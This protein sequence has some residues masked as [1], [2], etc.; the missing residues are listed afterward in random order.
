MTKVLIGELSF[1]ISAGY[2]SLL[3]SFTEI[4][5]VKLVVDSNELCSEIDDYKPDIVIVNTN[6]LNK[7]Q[8]KKMHE[9]KKAS[10][11]V[12]HTFNT[13]LPE[14]APMSQMSIYDSRSVLI[15]KIEAC[16][17]AIKKSKD[18]NDAEELSERERIILQYVALGHTNKE[19]AE[20]AYIST[21]TVISHRK[22]ITRKLGI[23][24]VSGLT[25]YAILNN[26]IK[27]DDIS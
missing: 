26:I 16:L 10:C 5:D 14:D 21:H 8:A 3:K 23:K 9:V 19:I 11:Q 6:F 1:I 4:D 20:K 18:N 2:I 24:T 27:M 12:V 25:V 13:V 17:E 22:N 15:N 7:E